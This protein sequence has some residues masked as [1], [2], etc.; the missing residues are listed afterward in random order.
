VIAYLRFQPETHGSFHFLGDGGSAS[1]YVHNPTAAFAHVLVHPRERRKGVG[2]ALL[3]ALVGRAR[4]EGVQ[5]LHA[6]HVTSAGAAFAARF[7]FVD[8]QRVVRSLLDLPAA[9]LPPAQPPAGWQLATW[10]RRV[11]ED[12]L[13][14]YVTARAAMDDAPAPE[15][16]DFPKWT[17]ENVRA[18]E[19]SLAHRDREMR[20]TVA[21]HA[22]GEIGAFTELRVSRG[23]TLGLTDDTGTVVAHRRQGLAWAV[24]LESLRHLRADHP[25]I[26]VVSTSNAEENTAMRGLNEA[27]G[28]R[29]AA[30]ETM[31]AL[32]LSIS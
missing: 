23:S 26:E 8:G 29:P 1:L 11:P 9:E 3:D 14:A 30:T 19:E 15:G 4:A 31:T 25:E 32:N 16:M 28:F 2:R 22:D 7:G 13:A 12:Q 18:S 24:K 6:H 17:A 10:F 5:V 27:I 20:L 21:I